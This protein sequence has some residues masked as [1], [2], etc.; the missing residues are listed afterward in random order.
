[1]VGEKG[2]FSRD[3]IAENAPAKTYGD[4]VSRQASA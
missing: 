3:V 2:V 4:N 1:M